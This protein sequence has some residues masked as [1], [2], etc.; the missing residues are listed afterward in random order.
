MESMYYCFRDLFTASSLL[1]IG[2]KRSSALTFTRA[3]ALLTSWLAS[4]VPYPSSCIW[5][6]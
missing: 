2:R 6:R 1:P 4:R 5:A 3:D